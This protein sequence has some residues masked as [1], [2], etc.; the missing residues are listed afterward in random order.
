[1]S[2]DTKK[3]KIMMVDDDS[4]LL[5]MYSMK[6]KNAGMTVTACSGAIDALQKIEQGEKP[7]ILMF[8]LIM[9]EMDGLDFISKINTKGLVPE[10]TKIVVTNQGQQS[11][12][13][14]IKDQK[15]DGY[16]IKALH[17]PSEVLM[18]IL[19]IHSEKNN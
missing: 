6:F 13:E 3:M 16:I 4:F 15:V 17:T 2:E 5:D 8:D 9:P 19:E 12:L 18:K 10:S 7:D 11:D 14:N 1:M